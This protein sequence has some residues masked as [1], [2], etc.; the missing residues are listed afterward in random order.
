[1]LLQMLFSAE[2]FCINFRV[3]AE[4]M[5]EEIAPKLGA[6]WADRAHKAWFLTTFQPLVS[7]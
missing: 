3:L 7:C 1:M 4:E 6:V 2:C 5:L